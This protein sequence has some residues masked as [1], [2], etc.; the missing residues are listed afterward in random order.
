MLIECSNIEKSFQGIP[1]L[2]DITFKVE[3]TDKIAIIG[4]NGAGKT[5]ILRILNDE[6]SYDSGQ[7]FKNKNTTIGYLS[8]QH[9]LDLQKTVY[10]TGLDALSHIISIEKRLRELESEMAI[11]HSS[12]I[13][14]TYDNLTAKFQELGGFSYPSKLTGVLK[15]LGFQEDEFS[16]PVS[17]LSGGQKTR[18]ALAK[19]LLQEPTLL[20]L[21]EPTNHLD[22]TAIHFLES[23]LKNYPHAIITVSHDRYFIDQVSNKIIEIE[24][25]KSKMYQCKYQEYS[26]I[27]QTQRSIDLKHYVNQQKEIKRIQD[28]IDLLKSYNKEKT[29][30]R[31]ESKEKQLDKMVKIDQ[32]ENLPDVISIQFKPLQNSGFNVLNIENA[33]VCFDEP[34]FKNIN[35]DIKKQ[36][37]IALV[38][39]NGIGK[40][41][42][43]KAILHPEN[44]ATGEVTFGSKIDIAYYDQEHSSLSLDKTVFKEISDLY[45]RLNNTQIRNT[46]AM[47]NFKGEDVFKEISTLSGGE[48]GRVVLTTILLKQA[49]FLLLDEPT[50]HLDISSKEVLEEAL[51]DF[52]GTIFFISHDRYFINKIATKII[53]LTPTKAIVYDGDY[54]SYIENKYQPTI[55][56]QK[57]S[58]YQDMK[59]Q[60]ADLRK[61]RNQI[62]K[63]ENDISRLEQQISELNKELQSD[64]VVND[65][66]KY[67][68]ITE[69]LNTLEEELLVLM[70]TW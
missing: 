63:I 59:K 30:K 14:N 62:K 24:H 28:S 49:N 67:N 37:R 46:L 48:R 53:E 50:N 7:V 25:G 61:Q 68:E 22:S 1:V 58:S 11:D 41:T 44:L 8:Q 52:E 18:L 26:R 36:E 51:L 27:K 3:D 60:Q 29:V 32:P 15:G 66:Q 57:D 2:K 43:F 70:D 13:L 34:L 19:L 4:V 12:D 55:T 16:F 33:S 10:E 64:E 23:Y 47:F 9:H 65:Y 40:T 6:E 31:A 21:D 45:P 39:D 5:T 35:I 69:Q 38:G 17:I 20:L 56:K 54:E 42:L